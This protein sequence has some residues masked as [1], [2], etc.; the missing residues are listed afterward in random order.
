M[1]PT[2]ANRGIAAS[3]RHAVTGLA[4]VALA[5]PT[6]VAFNTAPSATF[7]NQCAAV[8][9]WAG[10]LIALDD[11][12]DRGAGGWSAGWAALAG[13]LAI[14]LIWAVAA[15]SLAAVPW[16]LARSNGAMILAAILVAWA[17]ARA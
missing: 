6:L 12:V 14:C 4:C 15:S 9:G 17:A 3:S 13:G 11:A 2:Q 16:S 7:F 5:L 8:M 1:G 10:A